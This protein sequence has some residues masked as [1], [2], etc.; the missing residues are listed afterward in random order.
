L[1]PDYLVDSSTRHCELDKEFLRFFSDFWN[2][3]AHCSTQG[4]MYTFVALDT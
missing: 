3:D 4:S 2:V 1:F